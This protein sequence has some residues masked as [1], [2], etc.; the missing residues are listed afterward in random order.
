MACLNVMAKV[1][2]MVGGSRQKVHGM[3]E[4]HGWSSWHGW[5]SRKNLV[6]RFRVTK[7]IAMWFHVQLIFV[8]FRKMSTQ[9][10]FEHTINALESGCF[11]HFANDSSALKRLRK[12]VVV[13]CNSTA[14]TVRSS[15]T[16]HGP[17]FLL[18]FN[19]TWFLFLVFDFSFC[20]WVLFSVF[21]HVFFSVKE[22]V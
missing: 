4:C 5:G 10:R 9:A 15:V 12:F 14:F 20:S 6:A 2:G 7:V 19:W 16:S 13:H 21:S 8:N 3:F 22:D 1:R 11:H 17:Y 18:H